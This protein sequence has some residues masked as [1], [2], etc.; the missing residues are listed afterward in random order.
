MNGGTASASRARFSLEVVFLTPHNRPKTS[1]LVTACR[2]ASF[3]PAFTRTAKA[4]SRGA[5]DKVKKHALFFSVCADVTWLELP[6]KQR[7][8]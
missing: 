5:G 6:L 8:S 1:G 2:H 4:P 7:S 3:N